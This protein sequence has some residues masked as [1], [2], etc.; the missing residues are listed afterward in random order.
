MKRI[1]LT[2]SIIASLVGCGC[3][4]T[5]KYIHDSM[6]SPYEV[7]VVAPQELYRGAI[8]DSLRVALQENVRM[9][10]FDEPSYDLINILPIRYT[11]INMRHRNMIMLYLDPK[12]EKS[13]YF[14]LEDEKAKPQFI[15]VLKA[16]D[17]TSMMNLIMEYRYKI[18]ENIDLEEVKRFRKRAVEVRDPKINKVIDSMFNIITNIPK[19]YKIRNTIKPDFMWISLETSLTSQGVVI[20][21]YPFTAT[22]LPDSTIINMRNKFLANIP[23][24]LPGGYM[25]TGYSIL[26]ET[27]KEMI[28]GREWY[29]T[30]GFWRIE[31]DFMGGPYVLFSTIDAKNK[32]VVSLDCYVY[33]P[34]TEKEQRNF[35]SQ[36]KGIAEGT[37]IK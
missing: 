4:T 8:G 7:F 32:R 1:L 6:G 19:G 21:D 9:I 13:E 11:G 29:I 36:M 24:A 17:T 33:S 20:Y 12:Y 26:S 5:T 23:G 14:T 10:N 2:I 27:H 37:R 35:I 30:R 34:D 15:T 31:N 16:P 3:D 18:K 22:S 28:D 25:T